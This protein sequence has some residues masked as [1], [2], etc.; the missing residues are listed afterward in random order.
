MILSLHLKKKKVSHMVAKKSNVELNVNQCSAVF[1]SLQIDNSRVSAVHNLE[2]LQCSE[3]KQNS[4]QFS[5][6]LFYSESFELREQELH[7]F[8]FTVAL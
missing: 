1:L 6:L 2:K 8:H 3:N 5:L 7:D 4:G